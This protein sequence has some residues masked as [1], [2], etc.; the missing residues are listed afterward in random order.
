MTTLSPYKSARSLKVSKIP[1][2]S[3]AN[4]LSVQEQKDRIQHLVS[5]K[6]LNHIKR[7]NYGD[8]FMHPSLFE[9]KTKKIEAAVEKADRRFKIKRT[10][11]L[12]NERQKKMQTIHLMT[13][14][15]NQ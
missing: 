14:Y 10:D 9:Q 12:E 6:E 13:N 15:S 4:Y 11:H 5:R 2:E 1:D 3:I 7:L 8:Y